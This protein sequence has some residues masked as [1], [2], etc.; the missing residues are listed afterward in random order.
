MAKYKLLKPAEKK[1]NCFTVVITADENDAD[2][3]TEVETYSK[4]KFDEI[5]AEQL[6][7]LLKE[8]SGDH[9]LAKADTE[10]GYKYGFD[11]NLPRDS[12]GELCHTLETVEVTYVD[13]ISVLHDVIFD[14]GDDDNGLWEPELSQTHI[15]NNSWKSGK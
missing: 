10:S 4:K 2:Y 15:Y 7:K 8:F 13:E 12:R 1:T 5:Y 14:L 3:V 6:I 9:N 11:L